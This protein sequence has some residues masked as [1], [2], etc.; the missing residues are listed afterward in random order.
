MPV[1]HNA[2]KLAELSSTQQPTQPL[3]TAAKVLAYPWPNDQIFR[4][5]NQTF[6]LLGYGSLVNRLSAA[7]IMSERTLCT[8]RPVIAWGAK[9]LYNT[10]NLNKTFRQA[11]TH[12]GPIQNGVLN[13]IIEPGHW[14]NAV[15]YQVDQSEL[16]EIRLRELAY[17][18][19]PVWVA[20]LETPTRINRWAYFFSR[21][22]RVWEGRQILYQ[23]VVPLARYHE[24]CE[25]GC[26]DI[27]DDFLNLFRTSTW[28]NSVRM[29][30]SNVPSPDPA[31]S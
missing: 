29:S 25:A 13:A 10:I 18:L 1:M 31:A 22:E 15:E 16:P 3:P 28:M 8:A 6:S 9:R 23:N 4:N 17:D 21:R 7:E 19:V 30:L 2:P 5:S 24:I 26:R 12:D 14:F 20:D 11:E 27:S